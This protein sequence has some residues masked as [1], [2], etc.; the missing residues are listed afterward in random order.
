[1]VETPKY[2]ISKKEDGIEIRKYPAM[3]LASVSV[4]HKADEENEAFKVLADYIFGKNVKKENI[5]MT[6]PVITFSDE[7]ELTM[8]FIMPSRYT[9]KT[10]PKAKSSD[11][12]LREKPAKT[13][14]VLKFSG[15]VN[16]EKL[17][18]M[19]DL[20]LDGLIQNKIII[21]GQPFL[22]RYNSPWT[23]PFLR[24]NEVAIEV[25]K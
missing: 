11:I 21:K 25:L 19:K 18:K 2:T 20:L 7:K 23:L 17:K 8:S 10:L 3:L 12:E 6:A 14:A 1:M 15:S 16:E 13:L 4:K 9:K 22:M 5:G 24:R